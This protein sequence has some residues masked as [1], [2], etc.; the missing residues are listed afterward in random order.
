MASQRQHP[1]PPL[2]V[3]AAVSKCCDVG[4]IFNATSNVCEDGVLD[5]TILQFYRGHEDYSDVIEVDGVEFAA[6]GPLTVEDCLGA[7]M[8]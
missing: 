4:S 6:T 2:T 7:G 3:V 5:E 1:L 8:R